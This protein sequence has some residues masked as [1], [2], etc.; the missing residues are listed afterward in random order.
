MHTFLDN[1]GRSWSIRV[2]VNAIRRVR[3]QL[4]V[5]LNSILSDNSVMIELAGDVCKLVDVIYVLV[6]PQCDMKQVDAEA[7]GASL[8]GDAIDAAT[9]ALLDAIVD[10]FPQSRRK[11]LTAALTAS[12]KGQAKAMEKLDQAIE[13]GMMD[14]Q[15][16]KFLKELD[17]ALE[18]AL[19]S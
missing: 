16:D 15:M 1:Q 8:V 2:D 5:D 19:S 4:G 18:T 12:R 11:A 14:R 3:E 13:Q 17:K 10:F 7:F 6:K 9:E